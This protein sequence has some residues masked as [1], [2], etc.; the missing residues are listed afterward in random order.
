MFGLTQYTLRWTQVIT[1]GQQ[2]KPGCDITCHS[3]YRDGTVAEAAGN[4]SVL[5][6]ATTPI[7]ITDDLIFPSGYTYVAEA[8]GALVAAATLRW[9]G[10]VI[11]AGSW[12]PACSEVS[13]CITDTIPLL[14]ALGA[15]AQ[16][17]FI[18][19]YGASAATSFTSCPALPTPNAANVASLSLP[20]SAL[21]QI[22]MRR[23][24]VQTSSVARLGR[25]RS[26][27]LASM[28]RLNSAVT[29]P[30]PTTLTQAASL[31]IDVTGY[32]P[33]SDLAVM[34]L[35]A[36]MAALEVHIGTFLT[37]NVGEISG[38]AITSANYSQSTARQL[39]LAFAFNVA[40]GDTASAHEMILTTVINELV[41]SFSSRVAL[42]QCV[43]LAAGVNYQCVT[44]A[45]QAAF[46]TAYDGRSTMAEVQAAVT[47]AYA[48]ARGCTT[49][50]LVSGIC[51]PA[52][53]ATLTPVETTYRDN[54]VASIIAG[55]TTAAPTTAT[56]TTP[57]PIATNG[58][59]AAPAPV[60]T[61]R[62][63]VT[64]GPTTRSPV[65]IAP[66]SRAPTSFSPTTASQAGQPTTFAPT[67]VAPTTPA[68]F[69]YAP[70]SLAPVTFEPTTQQPTAAQASTSGSDSGGGVPM[71]YIIIAVAAVVVLLVAFVVLRKNGGSSE[72]EA[73]N[74]P[75]VMAFENPL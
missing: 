56:P 74:G 26:G 64:N 70:A 37:Q 7:S 5:P 38:F 51:S 29:C 9:K 73:A 1:A 41:G 54:L 66:T 46:T 17:A 55:S 19:L 8:Y 35:A 69:T 65:T 16:S 4:L 32:R 33:R 34:T 43:T 62:A 27:L 2:S 47:A 60:P 30:N 39:R 31:E 75:S 13:P 15:G 40:A 23:V 49:T 3:N 25:L 52:F 21:L 48:P 67:T 14:S 50:D 24:G 18:D 11:P 68:P 12:A 44:Q 36:Q 22:D 58:Q 72:E 63:P 10:T 57:A 45:L 28:C 61:T 42:G 20:P 59:T 6:A 71:L 53:T